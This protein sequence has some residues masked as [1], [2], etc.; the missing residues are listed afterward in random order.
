MTLGGSVVQRTGESD[1]RLAHE[2][3]QLWGGKHDQVAPDAKVLRPRL[4]SEDVQEKD[5]KGN[6][7][8]RHVTR[9]VYD[10]IPVLL[11]SSRVKVAMTL[12]QRQR[13]LLWYNTYGLGFVARYT[14][15]NPDDA[16]RAAAVHLA[17]PSSDALYD[18]FIFRVNGRESRPSANLGQGVTIDATL[19]AR[20]EAVVDVAYKTRGLGDWTYSFGAAGSV[21]QVKDFSL[22]MKTDFRNIDFPLGTLSP[23]KKTEDGAGY[24]LDWTF[25]SLVTG[26]KIGMAP[27]NR[28]N[29]GPLAAR[30]TFFA[31][32]SL[33]F[34]MTVMVILGVLRRNSLHPM[35]YFF[36]AVAFF[37]F[38]LLLA[39]LADQVN[40]HAAFAIASVASVFLVL[41]YLRLVGGV[42]FALEA[43][44]A[45][46]VFLVF[47]SYAF[48]FEGITGLTV[49]IGAVVT[50]FVLMQITAR[51]DW[52]EVF[53]RGSAA[54][55]KA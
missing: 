30:I 23:V 13:G 17:F 12:D 44:L 5:A 20:G 50:L 55:P 43:G 6:D 3:A 33:L 26:Q 46:L 41:T 49:T 47:F 35:S 42:R 21:A 10:E 45:Q 31:P 39:Y 4:V 52:T 19:P 48:F 32:V 8:T 9:W 15:Q 14:F 29:P 53:D 7:V 22:E 27:P 25:D 16:E 38:H 37:A 18:G 28:L 2:V 11:A 51:V 1:A 34:F 24:R 54:A 36:L 40:V